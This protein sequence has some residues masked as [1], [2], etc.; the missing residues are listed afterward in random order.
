[1]SDGIHEDPPEAVLRG[2]ALLQRR[3]VV[4]DG[5]EVLT[6][7][8]AGFAAR[9]ARGSTR[10]ATVRLDRRARLRRDEEQRAR[11]VDRV[12][13]PRAIVAGSVVSSTCS[14]RAQPSRDGRRCSAAGL[15]APANCRPCRAP[16]RRVKP[17]SRTSCGERLELGD[18]GRASAAATSSQPS[19]LATDCCARGIA[20]PER[21]VALPDALG[22]VVARRAAD[23]P[24]DT[25]PRS[26]PSAN[27]MPRSTFALISLRLA[28]PWSRR[29][30]RTTSRTPRRR[31]PGARP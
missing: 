27:L 30:P 18:A 5:D 1:M 25:P 29:S 15:P 8:V 16:R 6:G 2:R 22:R 17:A 20:A 13:S 24:L 11:E 7:A 12:A 4:G 28:W 10:T 3:A 21:R 23:A 26:A 14:V 9:R 31:R 19:R